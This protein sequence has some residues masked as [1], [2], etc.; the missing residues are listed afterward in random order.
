[1][2]ALAQG[3]V[4]AVQRRG[5]QRLYQR[6]KRQAHVDQAQH[7]AVLDHRGRQAQARAAGVLE[8]GR[9]RRVLLQGQLKD[10]QLAV[11][12]GLRVGVGGVQAGVVPL[13]RLH[14]APA[15]G[16]QVVGGRLVA[17]AQG[18]GQGDAGPGGIELRDRRLQPF[19]QFQRDL[20]AHSAGLL[21]QGFDLGGLRSLPAE[22]ARRQQ[23][24]QG[25]Q[26]VGFHG[27]EPSS[28]R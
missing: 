23:R 5:L 24:H 18:R 21:P 17:A 9:L 13:D 28:C 10:A 8:H 15:A 4:T 7:L 20:G 16:D 22:P 19:A 25:E 12:E 14:A 27:F 2:L 6:R 26:H 11:A 1:M 3:Q